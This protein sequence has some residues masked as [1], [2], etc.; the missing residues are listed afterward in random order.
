[1]GACHRKFVTGRARG[2]GRQRNRLTASCVRVS[3]CGSFAL[4]VLRMKC[5][6][7]LCSASVRCTGC[8]VLCCAVLCRAGCCGVLCCAALSC[9]VLPSVQRAFLHVLGTYTS[10]RSP[11][12]LGLARLAAASRRSAGSTRWPRL[13][14]T[15]R[16][17]SPFS[18]A[19]LV[20]CTVRFPSPSAVLRATARP[21]AVHTLHGAYI[22]HRVDGGEHF[23]H[24]PIAP[25]QRTLSTV[26][27]TH[28]ALWQSHA[29]RLE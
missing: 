29:L 2:K 3:A 10:G 1:M 15:G 22:R 27:C 21:P 17:L 26:R 19:S 7:G 24:A 16:P 12:S 8:A 18:S 28:T 23:P 14:R 9:R 13:A 20:S 6:Y 25:H 11:L 5:L 4:L